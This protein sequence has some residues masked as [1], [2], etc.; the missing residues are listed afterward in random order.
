MN[1]L[2]LQRISELIRGVIELLWPKPHGL[3]AREVMSHIPE[4][5]KLTEY[6]QNLSPSTH[7]PRYERVIRLA[8]LPL[9]KA[10]WLVKTSQGQWYLTDD[11]RGACR[12]FSKP[13]DFYLESL[14]ISEGGKPTPA[15]VLMS[16]EMVQEKAWEHIIEYIRE[17]NSVD[18]RRLVAV[19][20][21][22]MQYHITWVAPPEKKRGLIDMVANADILGA[23][24]CRILVEV[25]HTGQPV[26]V[27]GLRSF[28]ALLRA[29]DFGLLVSTG[30]FT[31]EVREVLNTSSFQKVNAMDPE[32][33][34]D[35]W[36]KHY[37]KLGQEAHKLL[38]LKAVYFLFPQ[39]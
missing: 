24:P 28:H 32:K 2:S 13:A 20:F 18:V 33:F 19:L 34:F 21:E 3:S 37:D 26:T 30:G 6:E 36:V 25:K 39:V 17:K 15:E 10:G 29:K 12:R 38:P 35:I 16:L 23:N 4:V 9:V 27:E 22:A 11:G 14:R 1:E 5:T 7:L 8:T 31:V